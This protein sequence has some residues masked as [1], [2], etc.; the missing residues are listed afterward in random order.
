MNDSN[1][2]NRI[3][4][5]NLLAIFAKKQQDTQEIIKPSCYVQ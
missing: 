4:A 3:E 5:G 2:K 1:R